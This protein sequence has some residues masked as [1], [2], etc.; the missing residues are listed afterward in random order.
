MKKIL[1]SNRGTKSV[2]SEANFKHWIDENKKSKR[3]ISR[4]DEGQKISAFRGTKII[5]INQEPKLIQ[6]PTKKIRIFNKGT[7]RKVIED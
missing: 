3:I 4:S 2:Y 6:I 1:S 7:Q 5:R